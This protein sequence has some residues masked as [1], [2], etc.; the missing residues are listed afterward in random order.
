[1]NSITA[2]LTALGP[3]NWLIA[4][5]ILMLLESVVPGIHFV[6][7]GMAAAATGTLALAA[8]GGGIGNA[9]T[10]PFQLII[11]GLL[12]LLSVV[13]V[14]RLARPEN[15]ASDLPDLNARA[16]QYVGRTFVVAEPIKDGRGK[17]KVGDSL[18]MAEGPDLPHGAQVRVT[19]A[20]G[21]VL[22]VERT[23]G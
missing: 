18:W 14:R 19:G 16:A 5:V 3:W 7:F 11:F 4:A 10:W 15:N 12:A 9:F 17:V 2:F 22:V 6:W 21:T 1:M 23:A 13:I 20:R 8:A